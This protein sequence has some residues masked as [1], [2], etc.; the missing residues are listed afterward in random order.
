MTTGSG[1]G[2]GQFGGQPLNEAILA[3]HDDV[4]KWKH[5]SR[6]W[7]FVRG[8]QRSPL[9]SSDKGRGALMFSLICTWTNSWVNTRDAG[10]LK[11]HRGH[12]WPVNSPHKW[13]VTRKMFPFDSVI[14]SQADNGCHQ[15]ASREVDCCTTSDKLFHKILID[16][17]A[18][19]A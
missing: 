12:R 10:D 18:M 5:F 19:V 11:R 15:C 4:I 14:M 13:P 9:N 8:I 16:V 1:G 17:Q 2:L 7:P 6:Y 3:M